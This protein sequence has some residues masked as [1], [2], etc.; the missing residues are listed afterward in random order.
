MKIILK[1]LLFI[2]AFCFY[3]CS[4]HIP[5]V[6]EIVGMNL[7]NSNNTGENPFDVSLD[8]VPKKAYAIKMTLNE[9]MRTISEGDAQDNGFINQD[10]LTSLSILS[11]YNFDT[12]HPAGTSLNSYFLT[13][14]N[15]SATVS[16]FVSKGQIGAGSYKNG[17]YTDNW[18]TDQYLYL[19]TP[20]TTSGE[21]SFVVKIDLSDGRSMSDTINVKLY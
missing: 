18:N 20:P 8:S 1:T 13:S 4:K 5:A 19:M 16:A 6:Y 17:N 3:A 14:L 21:Q 9:V 7:G 2:S 12:T 15:S 11:L 10:Q